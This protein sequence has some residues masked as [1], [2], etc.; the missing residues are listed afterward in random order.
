MTADPGIQ[1]HALDNLPGAQSPHLRIGIQFVKER[2][3]HGQI[4]IGKEFHRLRFRGI[5][6][7]YR[8]FFFDSSLF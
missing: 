1:T 7:Q 6:K 8:N 4:S 3:P 2:H 5:G